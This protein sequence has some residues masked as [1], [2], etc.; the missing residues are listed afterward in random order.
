MKTN[1]FLKR[2]KEWGNEFDPA[3]VKVKPALRVNTLKITE[4]E[5][6]KK[7]K[8]KGV[9]LSKVSW[10]K[11]AYFYTSDFALAST[12]EYLQGYF[13][14]QDAASQIPAM[15][16]DPK[17]GE[18]VLD[19]AAAP[20]GK[21][22]Q[23]S[24]LMKNKGV[25]VALD[26]KSDRLSSLKNNIERMGCDNVIVYNKDANYA[27]DLNMQFDKV[28]LDAPCSGNFCIDKDWFSKRKVEDF[29][30]KAFIQRKLLQSGVRVLKQVGTI[31]YSTCS[32]EKEENEDVI[33]WAV[34][35]LDVELIDFKLDIGKAGLTETTS[36]TRRLW[37]NIS[38]T[39]G[40]F[41]AKMIKITPL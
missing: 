5:L 38:M 11:N 26:V 39:Q 35:T 13:Y 37:P 24:M 21:T 36:I 25:I 18:T 3:N 16:L 2:Y 40:F 6:V 7:L 33:D 31:V 15:V 4:E 23:L 12:P 19:M 29:N 1:I 27:N 10:L 20:G 32:L 41:V 17:P 9:K 30:E 8:G 28:L 34:S 14:L 22:T